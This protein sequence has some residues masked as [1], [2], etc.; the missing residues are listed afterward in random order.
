MLTVNVTHFETNDN[1]TVYIVN[2]KYSFKS[3]YSLP[4]RYSDFSDLYNAMKDLLPSNYKF[5]NKSIFSTTAQFTKE[6]RIKGF[7][8]MLKTLIKLDPFPV[9]LQKFLE[10]HERVSIGSKENFLFL[11]YPLPP[12]DKSK[13]V[14]N[15]KA[16]ESRQDRR[17][18][19]SRYPSLA[20]I[21]VSDNGYSFNKKCNQ[22]DDLESL[23]DAR[24]KKDFPDV[25]SSSLKISAVT[26]LL[27][28]VLNIV[29]VSST[30]LSQILVTL[31]ALGLLVS[32]VR[33]INFK[34]EARGTKTVL[35]AA[36]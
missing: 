31:L 20:N 4:K 12:S 22:H 34:I 25:F 23:I 10:L 6:R 21:S 28:V 11:S 16:V 26:Y 36:N 17:Y 15:S 33:V 7:D 14:G 5:P 32:F 2:V 30:N 13:S 19:V 24:V 8:E 9:A 3:S 35:T 27:C 1:I 29:D 18:S